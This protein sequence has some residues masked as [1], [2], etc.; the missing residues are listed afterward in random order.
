MRINI[1]HKLDDLLEVCK[2]C[3]K[4]NILLGGISPEKVCQGCST[5]AEIHQLGNQL[6]AI[7]K[8]RKPMAEKMVL[9]QDSYKVLKAQGKS[10]ADISRQFG[11]KQTTLIYYKKKW[12]MTNVQPNTEEVKPS[13][14]N[15]S[16]DDK[17]A[18]YE[19]VINEQNKTIAEQIRNQEKLNKIIDDYENVNAAC[20][21]VENEIATLRE[22]KEKL[23]G[24]YN[25]AITKQ[26]HNDYLIENQKKIIGDL[27][28]T[29]ERYACENRAMRE[30]LR[31]W[32]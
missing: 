18:E 29:L 8:E 25:S 21:D 26:Y 5:Y 7:K 22:E 10:D 9:D 28:K 31:Q 12:A 32:I 17:T 3:D 27:N 24:Q 4:R 19:R 6:L 20:E 13:E 30:L 1:L 11:I 15:C 14:C 23:Q 2:P 16:K